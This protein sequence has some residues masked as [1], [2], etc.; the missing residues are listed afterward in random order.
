MHICSQFWAPSFFTVF[1]TI[2]RTVVGGGGGRGGVGTWFLGPLGRFELEGSR[3]F[4]SGFVPQNSRFY[5]M[6][7]IS[8]VP[9][10]SVECVIELVML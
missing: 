9:S 10:V 8:L 7:S 6:F 2:C 3:H 4:G 5:H 1:S